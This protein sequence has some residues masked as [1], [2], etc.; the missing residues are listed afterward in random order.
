MLH[1]T[2]L[3]FRKRV[4]RVSIGQTCGQ[5]NVE[6]VQYMFV[7]SCVTADAYI[8]I[9]V[10]LCRCSVWVKPLFDQHCYSLLT[11]NF[12]TARKQIGEA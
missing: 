12:L 10:H 11:C 3:S 4:R 9:R 8:F 1:H 7:S 6:G 5:L 2:V